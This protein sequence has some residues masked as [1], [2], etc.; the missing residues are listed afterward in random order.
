MITTTSSVAMATS[1]STTIKEIKVM[2][3]V[4]IIIILA[5]SIKQVLGL[6]SIAWALTVMATVTITKHRM[7]TRCKII[8]EIVI[9]G[10]TKV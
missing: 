3:I 9:V 10:E 6:T 1:T 8:I 2:R 4:R 5:A 7:I